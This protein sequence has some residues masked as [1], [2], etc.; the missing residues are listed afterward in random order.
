MGLEQFGGPD[1][2]KQFADAVTEQ[3]V[4]YDDI[5]SR[6]NTYAV[7]DSCRVWYHHASEGFGG[8]LKETRWD[9]VSADDRRL[10]HLF[11][12]ETRDAFEE[13]VAA[14]ENELAAAA[15][16]IDWFALPDDAL[17]RYS[18][19]GSPNKFNI[20]AGNFDEMAPYRHDARNVLG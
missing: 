3:S 14:H 1:R 15:A 5:R 13:F 19:A 4:D 10:V 8:V 7:G 20:N 9:L 16:R 2:H 17:E 11:V 12:L 6:A 18:T